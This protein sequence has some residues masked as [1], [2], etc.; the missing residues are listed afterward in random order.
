ME[1]DL[2]YYRSHTK[3]NNEIKTFK[4]KNVEDVKSDLTNYINSLRDDYN[5][6]YTSDVDLSELNRTIELSSNSVDSGKIIIINIT[7]HETGYTIN[8]TKGLGN[9]NFYK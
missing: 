4:Y 9:I 3:N 1:K 8:I 5:Y 7:Y 2:Y 6:A